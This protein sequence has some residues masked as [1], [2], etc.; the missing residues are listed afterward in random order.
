MQFVTD[1]CSDIEV[2]VDQ[3]SADLNELLLLLWHDV[4][5]LLGPGDHVM[6]GDQVLEHLPAVPLL[7]ATSAKAAVI[8]GPLGSVFGQELCDVLQAHNG[9]RRLR[10]V[11]EIVLEAEMIR[12]GLYHKVCHC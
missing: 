5:V 9:A 4:A 12:T 7:L 10:V 1:N 2:S 8:K 6:E 3:C 11:T